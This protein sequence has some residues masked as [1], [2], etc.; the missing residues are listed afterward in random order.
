MPETCVATRPAERHRPWSALSALVAGTLAIQAV[1]APAAPVDRRGDGA[2]RPARTDMV[3]N[4]QVIDVNSIRMFVTNTGSFAWNKNTGNAGLEFPKGTGRTCVFAAGLW[5]GARVAGTTRVA[6]S[7]YTDEYGPGAMV[8]AT[9]DDPNKSEYKVYKLYR[10]YSTTFQRDAVLADYN[11]G[12]V[13]HGAPPVTVLSNG[14]LSIPGDQMLWAVYNDADPG[15]HFNR[16]GSTLPLGVEVQQT[17]FAFNRLGALGNTIFIQYRIVNKGGNTLDSTYVSLWS[18]PDDGDPADDVV[19]CDTTL[20][21][22]YV[23]NGTESDNVYGAQVPS[24]GFDFLHGPVI[25]G[26]TLGLTSFNK[27]TNGTDPDSFPKTY[28]LMKGLQADGSQRVSPVTGQPTTFMFSGDPI[29]GSGWLDTDNPQD[30]RMQ[31]SSGPFTM[32]PG[33]TQTVLVAIVIGQSKNRLASIS[34]MKLF[35]AQIQTAFDS[36]F[37]VAVPLPS[38][39]ARLTLATPRPNPTTS[40]LALDFASARPGS[41]RIEVF[42]VTGRRVLIRDLGVLDAGPH[43]ASLDLRTQTTGLYLVRVRQGDELAQTRVVVTH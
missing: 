3:D 25:A 31:L 36:N 15:N 22:G 38:N 27:Y 21:V 43:H 9:P 40:V 41:A 18:D 6:V 5:I 19:G 32:A 28:N 17:T 20:S 8:G 14:S 12:A 2:I 13:P 33:D 16:A 39:P 23:Y 34:L 1:A 42:D 29:L 24:V 37:L 10:T 11:A 30:V 35:D 26:D 4:S 7:E